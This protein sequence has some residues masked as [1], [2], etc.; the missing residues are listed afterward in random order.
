MILRKDILLICNR[1]VMA[2]GIAEAVAEVKMASLFH[3]NVVMNYPDTKDVWV[4]CFTDLTCPE[5]ASKF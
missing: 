3:L 1:M 4:P 5:L 2:M